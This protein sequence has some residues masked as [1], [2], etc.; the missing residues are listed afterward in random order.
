MKVQQY[1]YLI[2]DTITLDDRSGVCSSQRL[3]HT[4][5]RKPLAWSTFPYKK[6][7]QMS[8]PPWIQYG[9]HMRGDL[10]THAAYRRPNSW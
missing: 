10:G 3:S 7:P 6:L 1:L 4:P 9:A 8:L 2:F 5:T